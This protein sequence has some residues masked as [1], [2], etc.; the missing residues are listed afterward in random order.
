MASVVKICN[1]ALSIIGISRFIN[2]I[3]P[4]VDDSQEAAMCLLHY[5]QARD[6]LMQEY[7]WPFNTRRVVLADS[8]NAPTN[9]QFAYRY[10]TDCLKA[11]QVVQPGVKYPNS[12]N[13]IQYELAGDDQG[14]L[15]LCDMADAELVYSMRAENPEVFPPLVVSALAALLASKIAMPLSAL[16][17]MDQKALQQYIIAVSRAWAAQ[18]NEQ[19]I[20][21]PSSELVDARLGGFCNVEPGTGFLY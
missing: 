12:S 3:D 11:L 1:L 16:P 4:T 20:R 2:D 18:A 13:K 8:G 7:P 9:W 19:F 15:I 14:T 5:E 6:E 10:P 21:E 17:G